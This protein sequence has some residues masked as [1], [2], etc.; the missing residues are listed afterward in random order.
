MIPALYRL[1][2]PFY[3]PTSETQV[4][5]NF[6]H[7]VDRFNALPVSDDRDP[8]V[9][10]GLVA[11]PVALVTNSAL[12]TPTTWV[13]L[14]TPVDVAV[15]AGRFY[16]ISFK[17]GAF[18]VTT[19]TEVAFACTDSANNTYDETLII[20]PSGNRVGFSSGQTFFSR[21]VDQTISFKLR[22][23]LITGTNV[24]M[25]GTGATAVTLIIEDIGPVED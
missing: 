21:S 20:S 19:A 16:K 17:G 24:R 25:Y 5:Q 15:K 6:A 23:Y 13:D 14:T 10:W 12:L 3:Q 11:P 1:R 7:I 4:T 9:S 8:R 2:L 18:S 22:A